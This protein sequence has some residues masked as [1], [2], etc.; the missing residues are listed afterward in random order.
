MYWRGLRKCIQMTSKMY[1]DGPWDEHPTREAHVHSSA[2]W[3]VLKANAQHIYT[4]GWTSK[5]HWDGR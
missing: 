3:N 2:W 5:M 4:L 1:W